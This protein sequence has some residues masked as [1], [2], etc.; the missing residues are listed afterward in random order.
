[1]KKTSPMNQI[2][3]ITRYGIAKMS[4]WIAEICMPESK[5]EITT[6][7]YDVVQVF[8]ENKFSNEHKTRGKP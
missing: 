3:R 1:M 4:D 5:M 8:N 7:N 2:V 6:N